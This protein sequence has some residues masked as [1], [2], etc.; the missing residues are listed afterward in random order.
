LAQPP[1]KPDLIDT[2]YLK[3]GFPISPPD[4][5]TLLISLSDMRKAWPDELTMLRRVLA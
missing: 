1:S 2:F 4:P 5:N 3:H